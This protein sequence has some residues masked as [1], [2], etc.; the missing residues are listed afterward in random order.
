MKRSLHYGTVT[1]NEDT[2]LEAGLR[3]AVYFESESLTGGVEFGE[4]AEPCFPFAAKNAGFFF[5]PSPGD[6][7][8]IEV[9][10]DVDHPNPRYRCG[11]YSSEDDI[12]DLFKENYPNRMGWVSKKGHFFIFDETDGEEIVR[13]G[14]TLGTKLSMEAD[15][16]WLENIIRDKVVEIVKNHSVNIG[17]QEN[18]KVNQNRNLTVSGDTDTRITKGDFIHE[19]FGDYVLR[20]QGVFRPEYNSQVGTPEEIDET[21]KGGRK[22][23]TGGGFSHSIGGSKAESII[24]NS[25]QTISGNE[26]KLVAFK[27]DHT[28][29][30]GM[31]ETIALGNRDFIVALGNYVMSILA[32]NIDLSTLVGNVSVGNALGG[33]TVSPAGVAELANLL[34]ASIATDPVGNVIIDGTVGVFLGGA[35]L[36]DIATGG[37]LTFAQN[38]IVDNLTGAPHLPSVKVIAK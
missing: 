24:S 17:G 15:G 30:T 37:V 19:V 13:L 25:E 33:F 23:T 9:E 32:G 1:R 28:Y 5:V 16:S 10:E 20:V 11:V 8:E 18:I 35:G 3:G 26:S 36:G 12:D 4:P 27:G 22:Y 7:I 6:V 21:T 14:H 29:G 34:G 2:D 38:P 31:K